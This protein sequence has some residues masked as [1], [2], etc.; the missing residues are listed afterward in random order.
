MAGFPGAL[1]ALLDG[2]MAGGIGAVAILTLGGN[3]KVFGPY[4]PALCLG[5]LWAMLVR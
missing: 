2:I 1:T 4:G 3:R 5:G